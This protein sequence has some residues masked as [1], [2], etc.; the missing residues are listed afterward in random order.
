M[1]KRLLTLL[2]TAA[3]AVSL[4]SVPAA[5]T[6]VAFSDVS[7]RTVAAAA[8]TLRLMGVLDGYGDGTFRPNTELNRAQFCKMAVYAMDGSDELGKYSTVTV[9]PDVKPSHWASSFINMAAK[10]AHVISGY[11]DGKFHPDRTVTAGQAVTILLRLLGYSDADIGGIWPASQM[12]MGQSIGLTDGV[13]LSDGNRA[14]TRAQAAKLFRNFLHTETKSG[15]TYYKLSDEVTL[16]SLDGGAGTMTVTGSKTYSMAHAKASSALVGSRGKVV[17]NDK[18]EALTFLPV[19]GGSTGIASGAVII[20]ADRSTAGLD[21][22]TGGNSYTIYKNGTLASAGDLR[23]ND[24]ATWNAENQTIRVCDT[25][26]TVYYENCTPSPAA[27]AT[28]EVLG[29]TTF[30]VLPAA[31]DSLA[32]FKPGQ[33]MTLLLTADGQVAGA[34]EPNS[35]ARSNAVGIVSETG[36]VRMLCGTMLMDLGVTAEEK[37]YGQVVRISSSKK[38]AANMTALQ[39]GVSGDLDIAARKLGSKTLAENVMVFRD[40][41]LV[42]LT[43]LTAG[44]I[45][46]KDIAYARTNWAGNVDLIVLKGVAA[47]LIYGR[48]IVRS[49][50][51]ED[52]EGGYTTITR[53]S[54]EYGNGQATESYE[55]YGVSDGDFVAAKINSGKNG[56]SVL[57]ELTCLKNVSESSWV[58][59]GAVNFGGKTYTVP[60]NVLCYNADAKAWITLDAALAY[61][62][63]MDLHVDDGIVRIISVKS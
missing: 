14:L 3:M 1:R 7:D 39:G 59:K 53:I 52:G 38:D 6:T 34:V 36:K 41:E 19:S 40:R 37:Y 16:L 50:K 49:Q 62:D 10:G 57:R 15:G 42:G 29:G 17:L 21:A 46:E 27:P 4:F 48:A 22:L 61:A 33:I 23:K 58:G 32:K 44:T 11:P 9:F 28:I 47:D 56:F 13:G 51:T 26:I 31:A 60:E 5:A 55:D 2:L 8:E 43:Q 54:V 12:A 20:Y 30:H 24:V 25:R 18:D 63:T 35:G 45:R